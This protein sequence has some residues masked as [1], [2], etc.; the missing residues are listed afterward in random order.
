MLCFALLVVCAACSHTKLASG[1][2]IK[3][4]AVPS[5]D[6]DGRAPVDDAIQDVPGVRASWFNDPSGNERLYVLE[7]GPRGG[8]NKPPLVLIHGVGAIGTGDYYPVLAELSRTRRVLAIDLPGFGRSNPEDKDFGPERLARSVDTVVRT[9]APGNIDVLGH[10]SGGSLAVLFAAKRADIVRR[11]VL[12]DVAGILRPEILLHGQLHQTLT[13]M[14]KKVPLLSKAV[15]KAGSVMIDAVQ[16]LVPNAKTVANTGLLGDSPG[17]LAATALLDFNFGPALAEVRAPTKILWGEKD[18]VMPTRIA[19][20]LDDRIERSELT[21]IPEAGHV[22]MKDQP[23][24]MSKL[25]NDYLDGTQVP[26]KQHKSEPPR[27]VTRDGACNDQEGVELTGDYDEIIV[28]DCKKVRLHDVRARHVII[29]NSEGR[30][31][32]TSVS[33]G[34]VVDDSD[35]FITGGDLQGDVAL[36]ASDSKLD[37]AGV[38]ITGKKAAIHIHKQTEIVLSVSELHSPLT[39]RVMHQELKVDDDQDL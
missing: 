31:D 19:H 10:S 6:C 11:L 21:F 4:G 15:E 22:P 5:T 35:L 14:R 13:P 25:V 39:N 27:N 17:V 37:I 24:S 16:A 30:L 12:V 8:S 20:L 36:Q 34:L 7:A 28:T 3:P 23:G 1:G 2:A 29:R 18:Y 26:G 33:D 32:D 9:C 38:V